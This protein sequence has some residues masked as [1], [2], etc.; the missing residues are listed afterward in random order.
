MPAPKRQRPKDPLIETVIQMEALQSPAV[1]TPVEL[2]VVSPPDP[3]IGPL[4]T[5]PPEEYDYA[6]Y[7]CEVSMRVFDVQNQIGKLFTCS[8]AIMSNFKTFQFGFS[9]SSLLLNFN[10]LLL[11]SFSL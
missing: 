9:L 10:F 8:V 1:E 7:E 5:K 2:P 11:N 4:G 3:R 6:D